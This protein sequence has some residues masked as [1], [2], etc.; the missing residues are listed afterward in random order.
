MAKQSS[1][2]ETESASVQRLQ[3]VEKAF[4][5]LEFTTWLYFAIVEGQTDAELQIDGEDVFLGIGK[6]LVLN[7]I[8]GSGAKVTLS[9]SG[10]AENGEILQAVRRG[11]LIEML[12]ID[13]AIG[14]RTYQISMD[15]HEGS[16]VVKLPDLFTDPA[17]DQNN[18]VQDPLEKKKN[19]NPAP[20]LPMDE[21]FILRMQ[22][23]EES[24]RI[25]DALFQRFVARRL[26]K[27]WQAEELALVRR[28]VAEGLKARLVQE[29]PNVG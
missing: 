24:E 23:L 21:I 6:K 5:G 12:S 27:A 8:D 16:L 2:P 9:G 3:V 11:A 17:E 15:A 25:V 1:A 13:A 19:K 7:A 29:E 14:A 4:L 28:S 26:T 22:A 10:L 20:D 18:T